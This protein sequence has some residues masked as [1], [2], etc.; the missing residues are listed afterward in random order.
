MCACTV[1]V[2]EFAGPVMAADHLWST[3]RTT[4]AACCFISQAPTPPL[5]GLGLRRKKS[6]APP[7]QVSVVCG[8][9]GGPER[10]AATRAFQLVGA[11][12]APIVSAAQQ[13]A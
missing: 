11:K 2:G 13:P 12:A 7:A 4:L 6:E 10:V 5:D 1:V 9:G 8:L 3:A